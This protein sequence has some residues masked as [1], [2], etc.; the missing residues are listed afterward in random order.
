MRKREFLIGLTCL[1]T[2]IGTG[3]IGM[4]ESNEP[5][6]VSALAALRPGMT[7]A[8][9]EKAMGLMWRAP[10]PHKGGVIDILENTYGVIVR[11]D[12]IGKIGMIEFTSR[13]KQTVAGVP[14]GLHL[15]DIPAII[16]AMKIGEES[17]VRRG[18]RLVTMRLPEGELSAEISY[19][20]VMEIVISNPDAEYVE[21][22]APPYPTAAGAP[23]APF[24]DPNLKLVV[25]SA[26]LRSKMLDLGTPQQLASHI[27]D[28]PVDLEDEG[29][30]LIPE[31]LD[32]LLRYPLTA[33]QLAAVDW[34]QF[35]GG[36]EIY[37]YAWYFWGG[38]GS[39]FD[40]HD[41][42]DLHRCPNLKGVSVIAMTDRF[43]LRTLVP[44]HRLEWVSINVPA[45]H[46]EALLEI[47]SLKRAGRFAV[48]PETNA[49]LEKLEQRGIELR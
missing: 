29:Y 41:T 32:Y 30:D 37:S 48:N 43:D 38:G 46:L 14:M 23:G 5:V 25:I 18:T 7:V 11:L 34:I 27:L 12:R 6:D 8:D 15:D 36:E 35:D 10:A 28:R 33:E 22:T 24:A 16:P 40:I 2:A 20:K 44:L 47:P 39:A 17:K 4:A 31:A 42:S 49:I 45:D 9:V 1:G 19:D 26:L 13:F 21:P 3:G